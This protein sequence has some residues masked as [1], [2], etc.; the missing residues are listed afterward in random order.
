MLSFIRLKLPVIVFL[1][2]ILHG[3]ANSQAPSLL[4][5]TLGIGGAPIPC[6]ADGNMI[7]LQQSVGQYSVTGVFRRNNLE[8][9]QGFIQPLVIAK[10]FR[11]PDNKAISIFPNPFSSIV[12]LKLSNDVTGDVDLK[13][14][15]VAGRLIFAKIIPAEGLMQVNLSSLYRGIYILNIRKQN[16]QYSYKIIKY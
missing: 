16:Y 12:Y 7:S 11:E 14:I 10:P 4:R 1:I 15:D 3:R 9:R 13:I 6:S 8:L 5:S 2:F